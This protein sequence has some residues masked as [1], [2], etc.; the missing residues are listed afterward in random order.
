[1]IVSGGANV[2]PAEVESALA[3]HPTSPDVVVIGL[4]DE[5]WDAG[6]MPS[7][8]SADGEGALTEEQVIEYAKGRLPRTR[9]RRPSSSSQDSAKPPRPRSIARR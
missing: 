4:A 3:G 9:R 1:M 7:S 2:F 8:S 6:C 5:R